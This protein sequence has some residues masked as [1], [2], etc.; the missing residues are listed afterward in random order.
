MAAAGPRTSGVALAPGV[1]GAVA[2]FA[3]LAAGCVA[4]GQMSLETF[5]NLRRGMLESE[6]VLR[7]GPPDLV[8]SPEGDVVVFGEGI[9]GPSVR[10][11]HYLPD[12][13]EHD[14]QLTVVTITR[15][16]VSALERRK[17][18]A[19]PESLYGGDVGAEPPAPAPR[20]DIDIRRDRAER[21]LDA[22]E[23]YSEVRARIK[24]RGH[25]SPPT[26]RRL[27]RGHDDKGSPYF[28]DVPP[29]PAE[30]VQD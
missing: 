30:P 5:G 23:E 3:A 11:L 13:A 7:A 24:A 27:Y 22:A 1:R 6:V 2:L 17:I 10:E 29:P 16:R 8:T 18:T 12:S 14:P 19:P 4:A 28:G 9:Y 26:Q 25:E 20:S 15:G 21:T